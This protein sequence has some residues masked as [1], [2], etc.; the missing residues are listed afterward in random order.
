MASSQHQHIQIV[1]QTAAATTVVANPPKKRPKSSGGGDDGKKPPKKA[2]KADNKRAASSASQ[3]KWMHGLKA[4]LL[5]SLGCKTNTEA[6]FA[7]A[8]TAP[9]KRYLVT[10]EDIKDAIKT[11][12]SLNLSND[13]LLAGLTRFNKDELLEKLSSISA[14]V[15]TAASL[16]LLSTKI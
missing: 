6:E 13:K 9:E 14:N 8:M 2:G 15:S 5:V 16:P 1:L 7:R 11:L 10:K 4:R 12:R 3:Y